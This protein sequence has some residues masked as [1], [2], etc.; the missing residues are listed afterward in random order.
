MEVASFTRTPDPPLVP[1]KAKKVSVSALVSCPDAEGDLG[2]SERGSQ[3]D[4]IV[5]KS[6]RSPYILALPD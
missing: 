6:I 4:K 2:A 5:E 3:R 1:V